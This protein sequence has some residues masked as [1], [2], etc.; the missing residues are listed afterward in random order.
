MIPYLESKSAILNL[1]HKFVV[2]G[3]YGTNCR[4]APPLAFAG[5]AGYIL[6]MNTTRKMIVL[7]DGFTDPHRAKTAISLMRYK[8]DEVVAVVDRELAGRTAQEVLGEGGRT[9]VVG[10]L[11]DAPPA[12]TLLIG[13]APPGGRVPPHWRPI[14]LEAI[15]RGLN[16]LSGLH[17]FLIDDA[18][19]SRAAAEQGVELIDVRRNDEHDVANRQGIRSECLRIHT[20][21]NTSSCGKMVAAIEVADGLKK[22]GLDAQFV[23]TGQTGIFIAGNGCPIDCVVSDFVAGAAEK[24][25]LANQQHEVL[26]IEGQG[27]LVHPRYSGVTLGLLHGL[28]PDGL[29]FCYEMGRQTVYGMDDQRLPPMDRVIEFYH[30]A[31]NIL[32]PC[33]IVGIAVNGRGYSDEEVAAECDRVSDQFGLPACDVIR[34][35]PAKLVEAVLD[36]KRRLNK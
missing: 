5:R 34:H 15:A 11:A 23:A 9:P 31:A 28:M 10:S 8:P 22:G 16:I 6:G 21:A 20:V 18:E 30:M 26:L 12:D 13:I 27:S 17:E 2:A 24:L 7:T 4:P 14:I 1:P 36:L 33:E 29:I 32:H 3:K 35:G 19:F 25:V